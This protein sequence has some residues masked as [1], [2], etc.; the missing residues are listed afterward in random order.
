MG[1]GI[2]LFFKRLPRDAK[3]G[4]VMPSLK[5]GIGIDPSR[6]AIP[7]AIWDTWRDLRLVLA[8]KFG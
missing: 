5:R 3:K 6:L 2:S 1:A 7:V 4:A 8:V